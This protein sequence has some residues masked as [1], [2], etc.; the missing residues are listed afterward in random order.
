[1]QPSEFWDMRPR[2]FWLLLEA[3]RGADNRQQGGKAKKA[4]P[5]SQDEARRLLLWAE[6]E[7]GKRSL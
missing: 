5:L 6:R 7:N 2:H 3:K 4:L 1:V